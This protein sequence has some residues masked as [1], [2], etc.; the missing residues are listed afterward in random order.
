M[1]LRRC[2]LLSIMA[3]ALVV[4]GPVGA[5]GAANAIQRPILGI[6]KGTTT[7]DLTPVVAPP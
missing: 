5:A 3:I 1:A 7:V 2:L 4:L 6:A